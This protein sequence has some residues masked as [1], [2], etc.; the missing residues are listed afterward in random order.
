MCV[1]V[2]PGLLDPGFKHHQ[3]LFD[4]REDAF[5]ACKNKVKEEIQRLRH[6][7]RDKYNDIEFPVTR[8]WKIATSPCI[9]GLDHNPKSANVMYASL[10][11]LNQQDNEDPTQQEYDEEGQS[12]MTGNKTRANESKTSNAGSAW[13]AQDMNP[14]NPD[15][16]FC[17]VERTCG[18]NDSE[19][20]N[21]Y[22]GHY[23][24]QREVENCWFIS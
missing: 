2:D 7:N 9:V 12:K 23:I 20:I 21:T 15:L 19:N 13:R 22:Q 16:K 6:E 10:G 24:L 17:R 3:A 8:R 1:L 14:N 5:N 4:T 11:N 18:V